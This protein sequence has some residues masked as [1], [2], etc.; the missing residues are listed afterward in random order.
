VRV[1][2][3]EQE[4]QKKLF[5][6]YM[7]V[8]AN[9]LQGGKGSGLGLWSKCLSSSV[10]VHCV[11]S[12]VASLSPTV[13]CKTI[14]EMHGGCVGACSP[15]EGQGS[16]FFFELPLKE[17]IS[18]SFAASPEV[19]TA[20]S[21]TETKIAARGSRI[22]SQ[23]ARGTSDLSAE[24]VEADAPQLKPRLRSQ[25]RY[26]S[27]PNVLPPLSGLAS[28]TAPVSV[29]S[30]SVAATP[31]AAGV[32]SENRV[33]FEDPVATMQRASSMS[34]STMSAHVRSVV[35]SRMNGRVSSPNLPAP[36]TR[37]RIQRT[38]SPAIE[39]AAPSASIAAKASRVSRSDI[40]QD[41][42][43]TGDDE[44]CSILSNE[45]PHDH[46]VPRILTSCISPQ[47]NVRRDQLLRTWT[48]RQKWTVLVADD[49]IICRKLML[50]LLQPFATTILQARDGLEAIEIAVNHPDPIDLIFVDHYMPTLAGPET[51]HKLRTEV[52]FDGLILAVSGAMAKEEQEALLTAG[53]DISLGKPFDVRSF[54]S[55]IFDSVA[56]SP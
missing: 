40:D 39:L 50:R 14:V 49:S 35:T 26:S 32:A 45:S 21:S 31:P 3:V 55:I 42:R 44:T 11:C 36:S 27:S 20:T 34:A 43:D 28:T 23:S 52:R 46:P 38:Q 16:T 18:S 47:F 19:P 48:Q 41:K 25:R 15:G 33:D 24:G 30:Q 56:A 10:C 53:A 51:I 37:S 29:N 22:S 7:Q 17:R 4:N 12:S 54:Q 5:Q 13:V 6:Q 8:D 1:A 9:K 2:T